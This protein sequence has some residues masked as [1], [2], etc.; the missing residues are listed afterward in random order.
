M[1]EK[2]QLIATIEEK[3]GTTF[4]SDNIFL[5]MVNAREYE[6]FVVACAT[7]IYGDMHD[8]S[9]KRYPPDST[10]KIVEFADLD[11]DF[12]SLAYIPA[13]EKFKIKDY[14]SDEVL[15]ARNASTSFMKARRDGTT[16]YYKLES[17]N[18]W[19]YLPYNNDQKELQEF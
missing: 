1:P 18:K 4:R 14:E 11:Q 7:G 8:F 13:D 16:W 3:G 5:A 2:D 9:L 10:T 6:D 15:L 19:H 17:D 12:S